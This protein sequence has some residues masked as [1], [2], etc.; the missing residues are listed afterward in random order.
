MRLILKHTLKNILAHKLRT[1]LL[2]ICI[3]V[4]SFTA[5]LCFDMSG[6]LS[7]MI[8]GLFVSMAGQTDIMVTTKSPMES[9]FGEGAPECTIMKISGCSS[10]FDRHLD[11]IDISFVN[12][13]SLSVIAVEADAAKDLKLIR[14]DIELGG[15][16][17]AI[18]ELFAKEFGYKVGDTI[19]LHGE[20][21]IPVEFTVSS[22]E[23][24]QGLFDSSSR[25]VISLDDMKDLT[26]SGEPELTMAYIDVKDDAKIKEAE[27]FFKKKYPTADVDNF[28]DNEEMNEQIQ[29]IT[30]IFLV[31]FA[32][33]ML[34]VIFVTISVCERM[35]VDKMSVVGTFRSLGISS[36]LT[37]FALLFENALFGLVGSCVGVFLYCKAKQPF[38]DTTFQFSADGESFIHPDV[39]K[40]KLIVVIGVIIGAVLVECL[41][42]IKEVIRAVKTPIRDIIFDTKDTEY[43]PGRIATIIGFVLLAVAAVT[44]FFKDSFVLSMTCFVSFIAAIALLFNY[45]HRF[46]AK[47]LEKLFE[48]LNLP[49]A[50][51]AAVEAG[52]KKCTVGSSVLCVT[53][54]SLALVIYIFA[55][56]LASLYNHQL[57]K[58][59][60]IAEVSTTNKKYL[61]YVEQLEGVDDVEFIYYSGDKIKF[62]SDKDGTNIVVYGWNKDGFRQFNAF[63]GTPDTVAEGEVVLDKFIMKKRGYKIGDE[64]KITFLSEGYLPIDK[65][66]KITGKVGIDY[67]ASSGS[68]VIISEEDYIEIYKD[69]PIYMLVKGDDP[70]ALKDTIKDHSAN[71]I[72]EIYTLPEYEKFMKVQSA[73][74][75]TI[76]ILLI[77]IGVGLTFIGVVSNQLIGLEGRKRECAVMTSVAMPRKKLSRMFLMEN[78]IAA[79]VSL[80][81]AVP[82]GV[83]M[84]HVFMRIMEILE[85]YTPLTISAK[86]CAGYAIVLCFVFTLV[87][88]FPIRALKKMDLVTQLKY[89]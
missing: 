68:A 61:S 10:D 31:L 19:I 33:C 74:I 20:R 79:A 35:I 34:L 48:K 41:C 8:R 75:K 81:A 45:V 65:T 87:S 23:K 28:M 17:V 70:K 40:A 15:K 36:K 57:F 49:I 29:G 11:D 78:F 89:E 2:I 26:V 32:I 85:T 39:P 50:H 12:R 83:A 3:A 37:T 30:R 4:C 63:E 55:N 67:N 14:S 62:G 16:K 44:F 82:I 53:A 76:I 56:S 84:S 5:M 59:D 1:L 77:V 51:L 46:A 54:A 88:L 64:I 21:D 60:I 72:S 7:S 38:F 66:L 27:E 13:E 73:S 24:K 47:L 42:P 6:S 9:S 69:H 18:S 52:A 25:A 22:I 71:Y 80:A 43:R 58:S 86:S